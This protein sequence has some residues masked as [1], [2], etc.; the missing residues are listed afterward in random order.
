MA[1]RPEDGAK[2]M[3]TRVVTELVIDARAATTGAEAYKRAM[4]SAAQ[5]QDATM[6][7]LA[8]YGNRVAANWNRL[9]ASVDPLAAAAAKVATAQQQADAAVRRGLATQQQAADVIARYRAQVD[10]SA[11]AIQRYQQS[12]DRA[13][14][15]LDRNYA[16][17]TRLA[18]QQVILGQAYRTGQISA[19]EYGRLMAAAGSQAA[20]AGQGFGQ[21]AT[22][23][24]SLTNA[25]RAA[26]AGLGIGVV[27]REITD[28]G[29]A[30]DRMQNTLKAVA[31]STEAGR[32]EFQFLRM[33]AN[34]L[35]IDLKSAAESY[36][37]LAAAAKGTSLEGQQAREIFVAVAEAM[38]A[39]GRTSDQTQGALLSIQQMMSKGTVQAEELRGQ[40]GER[41]PGAFQMAAKAM[42]VTTQQLDDMLKKGQVVAADFL[43]R[44]AQVLRSEWGQAAT[45]AANNLQA[46]FNRISTAIFELGVV[47][48]KSGFGEAVAAEAKRLLDALTSAE[49]AQ[50]AKTFGD[51]LGTGIRAAGEAAAFLARNLDLVA[52]A[53]A[54]FA[55][56]KLAEI[57]AAIGTA[58]LNAA[59]GI[60][61]MALALAS[62]PLTAAALTIAGIGVAIYELTSG[63]RQATA[64]HQSFADALGY[65]TQAAEAAAQTSK[66]LAERMRDEAREKEKATVATLNLGLAEAY[67]ARQRAS[68]VLGR[69]DAAQRSGLA[70]PGQIAGGLEAATA[71]V[72]RLDQIILD[73]SR[74]I[75]E[76]NG[77]LAALDS[78]ATTATATVRQLG[79]ATETKAKKVK[80]ATTSFDS[81]NESVKE[82]T[83]TAAEHERRLRAGSKEFEAIIKADDALADSLTKK[84]M[85]AAQQAAA[86][87]AAYDRLLDRRAITY[88]TYAKAVEATNREL[89]DA[90]PAYKAAQQAAE[91]YGRQVERIAGRA[92]D[93]IVDFA[94]DGLF[95]V[96]TG[97]AS[98]FWDSFVDMAA[99][100]FAQ[101]AAEALIRPIVTPIDTALI[102]PFPEDEAAKEA[103]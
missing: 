70:A 18:Q 24:N 30:F 49:V 20:S 42:G 56:V 8:D 59:A 4:A 9:K 36:G 99:R 29:L 81:L 82:A 5:A 60:R 88:E 6:V 41:L 67:A 64:A 96:L 2:W 1:P 19:G 7:R 27:L 75:A 47:I 92:T 23:I 97:R 34:R 28:A 21:A 103:A 65:G 100:A 37:G 77:R 48:A 43:P 15:A 62:N 79:T 32:A 94:G 74:K 38:T 73:A 58:A 35:G 76:A 80:E 68:G 66:T 22:G 46:N 89:R 17:N 55:A 10:G 33:E 57:I 63:T 14:S 78:T 95:G 85:P 102:A 83:A 50:A 93:R 3:T 53:A 61:A 31:G 72:T 12:L 45:E 16:A 90:D 71:T 39:L 84:F 87:I 69:L 51:T 13:R 101:I 26:V 52:Y 86:E 40:L 25:M 54:G 91:D 44:F 11:Q 98:N